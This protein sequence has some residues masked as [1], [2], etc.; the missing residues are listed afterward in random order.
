MPNKYIQIIQ[1]GEVFLVIA[2]G[3]DEVHL[4]AEVSREQLE[5]ISVD[6]EAMDTI[7]PMQFQEAFKNAY[8][9]LKKQ[10]PKK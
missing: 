10:I 7:I 8:H 9:E 3:K 1:A 6:E 5:D 2:V 4:L